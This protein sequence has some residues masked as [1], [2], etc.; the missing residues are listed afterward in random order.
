ME[1]CMELHLAAVK[2][3]L[4]IVGTALASASL[5]AVYVLAYYLYKQGV[6]I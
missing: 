4:L 3:F 1:L 5:F 6:L 2:R